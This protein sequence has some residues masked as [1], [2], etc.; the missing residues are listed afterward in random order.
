MQTHIIKTTSIYADALEQKPLT[1]TEAETNPASKE[2]LRLQKTDYCTVTSFKFRLNFQSNPFL[3][4]VRV[5]GGIPFCYVLTVKCQDG[6]E[7]SLL[8][9]PVCLSYSETRFNM[10]WGAAVNCLA[11]IHH[12]FSIEVW[13]ASVA[14]LIQFVVVWTCC[15]VLVWS[16]SVCL[17][18][19]R[20][21]ASTST[22]T[23]THKHRLRNPSLSNSHTLPPTHTL[24]NRTFII[25]HY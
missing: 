17:W 20:C 2:Q 24:P 15:P 10:S 11:L 6:I 13:L 3:Q 4:R 9:L 22:H 5:R 18:R 7:N 1:E 25:H 21:V 8:S 12:W 23:H 19:A 14:S 16:N